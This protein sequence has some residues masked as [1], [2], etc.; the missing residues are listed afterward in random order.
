MSTQASPAASEGASNLS[1]P[2]E[3]N[4]LLLEAS[5]PG[6]RIIDRESVQRL[7]TRCNVF[8][9]SELLSQD[10]I[11][12]LQDNL[13]LYP[14]GL[15]LICALRSC[16]DF[17]IGTQVWLRQADARSRFK[18]CDV[19]DHYSGPP[20]RI[21]VQ[22]GNAKQIQSYVRPAYPGLLNDLEY[23]F[24]NLPAAPGSDT[25]ISIVNLA[26][27]RLMSATGLVDCQDTAIYRYMRRL[28]VYRRSMAKLALNPPPLD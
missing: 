28:I 9:A 12:R 26:L 23:G 1:P 14:T 11:E 13:N 27:S 21:V 4:A 25:P 20:E 7:L 3:L 16:Q 22:L 2:D 15:P 8:P 5:D 18:N 17:P 24:L 6:R 10:V 19:I